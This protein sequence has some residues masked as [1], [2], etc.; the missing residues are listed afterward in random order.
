MS[1][2]RAPFEVWVR[3]DGAEAVKRQKGRLR[4]EDTCMAVHVRLLCVRVTDSGPLLESSQ[5]QLCSPVCGE[6]KAGFLFFS[7]R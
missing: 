6:T 1:T 2:N 7:V 5:T 3:R 4:T